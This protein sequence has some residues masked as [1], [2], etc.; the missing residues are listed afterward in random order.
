[1]KGISTRTDFVI[2][3]FNFKVGPRYYRCYRTYKATLTLTFI[4]VCLRFTILTARF[5]IIDLF[6]PIGFLASYCD[7]N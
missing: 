1:M 6:Q 5:Y 4:L 7:I 2:P 3:D